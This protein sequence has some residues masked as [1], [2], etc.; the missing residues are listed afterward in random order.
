MQ[1]GDEKLVGRRLGEVFR[2]ASGQAPKRQPAPA[3]DISGRWATHI[4]FAS[5]S[6]THELDLRLGR[7]RVS[8]VHKGQVKEGRV[9]GTVTGDRVRLLSSLPYDSIRIQH[10]FSW[11]ITGDEMEGSVDLGEFGKA[12]WTAKRV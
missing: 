2:A 11:Q 5:G 12:T 9:T 7:R 1:P 3:A 6:T 10:H 4:R 8:G